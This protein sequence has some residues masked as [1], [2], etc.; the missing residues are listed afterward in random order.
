MKRTLNIQQIAA[1][2]FLNASAER[3]GVFV[4]RV[5][6][7][8]GCCFSVTVMF[9]VVI[10]GEAVKSSYTYYTPWSGFFRCHPFHKFLINK[11]NYRKED[12]VVWS[13]DIR[14]SVSRRRSTRKLFF[15]YMSQFQKGLLILDKI[16]KKQSKENGVTA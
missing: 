15:I 5:T 14:P 9:F 3:E 1:F 10:C 11:T 13:L 12:L 16:K 4:K 7:V 8:C 2:E 6:L